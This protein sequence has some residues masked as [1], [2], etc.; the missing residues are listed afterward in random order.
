[1]IVYLNGQYLDENVAVVP[2]SDRGLL[3]GDGLFETIRYAHRQPLFWTEHFQRWSK[4]LDLFR[5]NSPANESE[6]RAIIDE[7]LRRNS[8]SDAAV[9]I[10]VTRGTGPRGYSPAGANHPTLLI[11]AHPAAKPFGGAKEAE[12]IRVITSQYRIPTGDPL[13]VAK[14]ANRLLS[15]LARAEAAAAGADDAIFLNTNG[16]VAEASGAN[17]FWFETSQQLLTPELD[18]GALHGVMQRALLGFA[19]QLGLEVGF[20][21]SP[22]ARVRAAEGVFLTSSVQLVVPVGMWDG[23]PI[24]SSPGTHRLIEALRQKLQV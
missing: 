10:T 3:Y 1:M 18:S 19:A 12:G 24:R 9:R 4:A 11:T 23:Q 14:H 16:E 7:L 15:V 13:A 22:L 21:P 17:L 2:V 6:L 20:A 5:L 8:S